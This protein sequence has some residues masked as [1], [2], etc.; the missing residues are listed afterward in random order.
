MR[1]GSPNAWREQCTKRRPRICLCQLGPASPLGTRHFSFG[2]V[3]YSSALGTS[4][5]I[6]T[7]QGSVDLVGDVPGFDGSANVS[8][9]GPTYFRVPLLGGAYGYFCG[10]ITA[11]TGQVFCNGGMPAGVLV[12]QDSAGAGKQGNRS[13][14][15]HGPAP[16]AAGHGDS[17]LLNVDAVGP[18][19]A[20]CP[21]ARQTYPPD[22]PTVF[23]GCVIRAI[24]ERPC[25]DRQR[26]DHGHGPE[27]GARSGRRAGRWRP[28][29]VFLYRGGSRPAHGEP[30]AVQ[31]PHA[32]SSA[33]LHVPRGV[34]SAVLHR[35]Q[36]LWHGITGAT[37]RDANAP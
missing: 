25:D 6:G 34:G 22:Q 21:T 19:A 10:R 33:A 30:P 2:G 32:G 16:T 8:V 1:T 28:A 29:G 13:S 36:Q 9:S 20:P 3:L 11:C 24:P 5:P 35:L 14:H 12:Q 7:P 23:D 18:K 27:P 17:Q 26:S 37:D 31:R 15:H 4:V